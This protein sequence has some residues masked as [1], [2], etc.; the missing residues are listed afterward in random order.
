MV[1]S[2]DSGGR[3]GAEDIRKQANAT[4]GGKFLMALCYH[5]LLS[6]NT[7]NQVFYIHSGVGMYTPG[8]AVRAA[9]AV[10]ALLETIPNSSCST[11]FL[12]LSFHATTVNT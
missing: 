9:S 1:S 5:T 3:L 4:C 8:A 7:D 10:R 2:A 6:F 11:T 12:P